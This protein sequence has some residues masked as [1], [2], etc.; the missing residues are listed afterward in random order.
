VAADKSGDFNIKNNVF[1]WS[2]RI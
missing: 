1:N 2:S